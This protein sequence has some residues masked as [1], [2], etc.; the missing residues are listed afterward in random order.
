MANIDFYQRHLNSNQRHPYFQY[1]GTTP[2]ISSNPTSVPENPT[3]CQTPYPYAQLNME[4]TIAGLT[5]AISSLQQEHSNMYTRQENIAET[6]VQVLSILHNIRYEY[7]ILLT[8]N[9]SNEQNASYSQAATN[10]ST[11]LGSLCRTD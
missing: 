5:N 1:W 4:N 11:V 8:N 6:L 2:H 3:I 9:R 7:Q 10:R